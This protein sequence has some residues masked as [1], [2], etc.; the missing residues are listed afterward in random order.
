MIEPGSILINHM[1]TS[2]EFVCTGTLHTSHGPSF[3]V[4]IYQHCGEDK[5]L[6]VFARPIEEFSEIIQL[7]NNIEV[8][9]FTNATI[10]RKICRGCG[11]W[12]LS[13]CSTCKTSIC[14]NCA[15][16]HAKDIHDPAPPED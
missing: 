11:D 14:E 13:L 5:N 2:F 9:R 12:T 15:T 7:P 16:S 10:E 8:S 3:E 1:G 6:H 4:G